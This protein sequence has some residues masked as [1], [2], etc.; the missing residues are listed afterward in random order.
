MKT[1]IL[2][3]V[4]LVLSILS[5]VTY[6]Q[7]TY[8]WKGSAGADWTI[9]S[10]WIPSRNIPATTD[11]L[12]FNDGRTVSV[13]N[14]ITQT[15]GQILVTNNTNISLLSS[16]A[17]QTLSIGGANAVNNFVIENGSVLQISS[18]GA[19]QLGIAFIT[20]T[21]QFGDISGNL[22][23]NANTAFSNSFNTTFSSTITIVSATGKIINNGGIVTGAVTRLQ[24]LSGS[25]YQHNM[26]AGIVPTASWDA[27]SLVNITGIVSNRTTAGI[28]QTFGHL[29]WNCTGQTSAVIFTNSTTTV[30]GDLRIVSTGSGSL[31]FANAAR[32]MSVSG[33]FILEGGTVNMNNTGANVTTFNLAG[34]F[35]Q[36]GGAFQRGASTGFQTINFNNSGTNKDF[37]QS[38]GTFTETG[39][40]FI[41]VSPSVL[42]IKNSF[43]LD[44]ARTFTV[45]TG[46]TVILNANFTDNGTITNNGSFY[47]ETY[48][49]S[50]TGNFVMNSSASYTLGI[51]D[52]NG[53]TTTPTASGNIQVSGTRT[54]GGNCN[55]IYNGTDR[56]SVV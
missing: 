22:I 40:N 28:Q 24:F 8:T 21:S 19:N 32:T 56:K 2:L 1:K 55:Y 12:K 31:D 48:T 54:F 51:G 44:V 15:V 52:P 17:S 14:V 29:T 35:N 42:T 5:T 20:G 38:A 3:Y 11:I 23:I 47:C 50:G 9:S 16:A 37:I 46:A 25:E 26:D 13:T 10:N 33:D 36:T 53:I 49:I 30:S 39:I 41:A 6:G 34:N 4:T 45:N 7:T 18:T 43:T 27:A